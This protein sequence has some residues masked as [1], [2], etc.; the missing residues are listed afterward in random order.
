MFYSKTSLFLDIG[1][2]K[3]KGIL[4]NEKDFCVIAKDFQEDSGIFQ[5][6]ILDAKKFQKNLLLLVEKLEKKA[7]KK[8][9][10]IVLIVSGKTIEHTTVNTPTIEVNGK[11]TTHLQEKINNILKKWAKKKEAWLIESY[12]I[13]YKID[14]AEIEEPIGLFCKKISLNSSLITA[15]LH[16]LGN[17]VYIIEGLGFNI[18]DVKTSVRSLAQLH[19][20]EDEKTLGALMIDFGESSINWGVFLN[21]K[22]VKLGV[23][24][25]GSKIFTNK[26][27]K[28]FSISIK[29]AQEIKHKYAQMQITP[30]S[31]CSW[32]EIKN[33]YESKNLLVAEIIRKILP[34]A[35]KI[36]SQ[37]R[38]I[39]KKFEDKISLVALCGGGSW[40]GMLPEVLQKGLSIAVRLS[41]SD[42][43][44]FDAI[45]GAIKLQ[46]FKKSQETD[47]KLIK[48]ALY[49][50]KNNF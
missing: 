17:I 27:A 3:L 13:K 11:I 19:L 7:K 9:K 24:K 33:E 39:I 5:G 35:E 25:N 32:A 21:N 37:I 50:L 1:T 31:F 46:K 42:E 4:I 49:W 40:I 34:E 30:E 45:Y 23:I 18:K 44:G 28:S 48:K 41:P 29:E 36:S 20:S 26:I 14:Q 43:P 47:K 10:D 16:L 2:W 22:L 12:P 15:P 6:H 8:V 38:D